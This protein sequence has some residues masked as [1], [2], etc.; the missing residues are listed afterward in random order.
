MGSFVYRLYSKVLQREP[1][2]TGLLNWVKQLNEKTISG[3]DAAYGFFFSPELTKRNLTNEEFV[4]L[5]Y[6]TFFDR[7][8]DTGGMKT[9]LSAL[10]SGA[11]R[12]YVF[13][14][15][16]NSQEWKNL[17]AGY[18]IEPGSYTS[19]EPRDQNLK[20]TAFVQRLY[21]LCLNR[22]ADVDGLN[23]WTKALNSQSQDGAHVAYG[24]FFS[25][26]FIGR[27]LSNAD[28]VEVLYE[29]LLGRG[30]D[31]AGKANWVKQLDAGTERMDIFRGFVHSQEFDKICADYGIVRGT[32]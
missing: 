14:G 16:A 3:S 25:Q 32:I 24:F 21:N 10:E 22:G 11:S 18:G 29:V 30:S 6:N 26:E 2:T 19:D 31:P 20:V 15:F 28:Y 4:T 5:L 1:D 17:C 13:S 27:K 8:P 23:N 9:W 12:K 7:N